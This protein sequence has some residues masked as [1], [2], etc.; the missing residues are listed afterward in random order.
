MIKAL[1][2]STVIATHAVKEGR[3]ASRVALNG[4]LAA[5]GT[6]AA[7]EKQPRTTDWVSDDMF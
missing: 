6:I 3:M 4:S 1:L 5:R 2:R 7:T